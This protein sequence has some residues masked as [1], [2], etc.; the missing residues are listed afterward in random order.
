MTYTIK[1]PQGMQEEEVR[2][3]LSKYGFTI[4]NDLTDLGEP[5]DPTLELERSDEF[6]EMMLQ[7][8]A[9]IAQG[10]Y[11]D[12]EEV[13]ESLSEKYGSPTR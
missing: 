7:A 6:R 1:A 11:Y 13:C 5:H 10:A 2:S 12:W 9:E 8:E 3:I 4:Y